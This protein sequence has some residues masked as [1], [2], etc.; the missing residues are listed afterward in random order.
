MYVFYVLM[1]VDFDVFVSAPM[2]R[3]KLDPKAIKCIFIGYSSNQKIYPT[4]QVMNMI[5]VSTTT[6][7]QP[8][9][10]PP[11]ISSHVPY[12]S[13]PSISLKLLLYVKNV[14]LNGNLEEEVYM[15][16]PSG[17][18][19]FARVNKVCKLKKSLYGLKQ[20]PHTWF[21]RFT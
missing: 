13:Y 18:N 12:N 14:F 7:L 15:E 16:I 5:D 2:R 11:Q 6:I 4:L 10:W 1:G 19:T 8:R 9:T 20:S 3:S 17:F 21:N